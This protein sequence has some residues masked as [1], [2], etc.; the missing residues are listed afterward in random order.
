MEARLK[1]LYIGGA[2]RSGSTL[3]EMILGNVPGVFAMGEIS[4][5]WSY[6]REGNLIC[7][8]GARLEECEVWGQVIDR[9][10]LR[11]PARIEALARLSEKIDRTRNLPL[12]AVLG[13]LASGEVSELTENTRLLYQAIQDVTGAELLIDSSKTPLH[14]Y[15][16][17]R[18]EDLDLRVLHLVRDARAVAYSWNQRSK[19][20]LASTRPG[21][22]MAR[23]SLTSS[24][25]RWLVENGFLQSQGGTLA[26]YA[27]IRYEDFVRQP[28][29]ELQRT[30]TVLG[31]PDLAIDML[32]EPS[33]RLHPT[34]SLGGNP[35]RFAKRELRIFADEEWHDKMPVWVRYGLGLLASPLLLRY[36]Y[37]L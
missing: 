8:C 22:Y 23:R 13:S 10:D 29:Q 9:L 24:V 34:H 11:S 31:L 19:R 25:L 17:K 16:L 35:V 33:L 12:L 5:F 30:L 15:L 7:G 36:K 27:L 37:P 3:L 18:I 26:H 6:L 28:Y 1:I 2:G 4:G 32:R 20:Q 21:A 14:L